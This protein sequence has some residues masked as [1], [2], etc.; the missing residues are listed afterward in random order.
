MVLSHVL[1]QIY[2][3]HSHSIGLHIVLHRCN[4]T[5]LF[6]VEVHLDNNPLTVLKN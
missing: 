3:T 2:Y 5:V 1:H 6:I 4:K